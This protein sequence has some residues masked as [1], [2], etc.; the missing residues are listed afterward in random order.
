MQ[1]LHINMTQVVFFRGIQTVF[2]NFWIY[3]LLHEMEVAQLF[4]WCPSWGV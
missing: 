4:F 3:G 1:N 2:T